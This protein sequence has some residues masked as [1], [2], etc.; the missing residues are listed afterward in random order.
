MF[1]VHKLCFLIRCFSF[2]SCQT[3]KAFV[4]SIISTYLLLKMLQ[5]KK[6][7]PPF[8]YACSASWWLLTV[9]MLITLPAADRQYLYLQVPGSF[10]HLLPLSKAVADHREV[11]DWWI[12][13]IQQ[14]QWRWDY[15]HQ[16]AGRADAGLLSLDLRLHPWGAPGPGHARWLLA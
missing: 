2:E 8:W 15:S 11:H 6:T 1:F 7:C 10:P 16:L 3:K 5:P 14:Q 12:S 13:E 4:P 9:K